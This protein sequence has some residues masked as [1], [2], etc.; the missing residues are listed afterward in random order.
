MLLKK[1]QTPERGYTLSLE[2][3]L[4]GDWILNRR[5]YGLRSK[6]HGRKMEVFS[7]EEAALKKFSDVSRTRVRRGYLSIESKP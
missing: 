7:S 1:F 4:F 5:W 2:Q 3:D 6:R